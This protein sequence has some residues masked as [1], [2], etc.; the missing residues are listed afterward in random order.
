LSYYVFKHISYLID[1]QKGRS[2]ATTDLLIFM[3]YSSFFPQIGAGPISN[4]QDTGKQL[5]NL[6]TSFTSEM[7]YQGMLHLT[8]G[9]AKTLLVVENIA[10]ILNFRIFETRYLPEGLAASWV[11][12]L[13]QGISLYLD[14]SGYTDIALGVGYLLGVTLPPNFDNP[15]LA[16]SPRRFWERWHISLSQWFRVYVFSPLSRVLIQRWGPRRKTLAQYTANIVT[17]TLVGLWHGSSVWYLLWG[18]YHGMLLNFN[19]WATRRKLRLFDSWIGKVFT[20]IAVMFGWSFFFSTGRG[21]FTLIVKNLLGF[22]GLGSLS[23]LLTGWLRNSHVV[24]I[25]AILVIF[26][27]YAEAANLSKIKKPWFGIL[28]GILLALLL[29]FLGEPSDFQYVQF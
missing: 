28:I 4:F 25:A 1:I 13:L 2:K 27:G 19:A 14:F 12:V 24:L 10:V 16:S 17:M 22:G 20:F 18:F 15:Y 26:S 21:S 9:I 7:G 29:M 11:L 3:A 8:V 5:S 23:Q 6:P